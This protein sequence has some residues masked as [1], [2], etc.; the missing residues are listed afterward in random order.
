MSWLN[1]SDSHW[2]GNT[3]AA[4]IARRT[5]QRAAQ[6]GELTPTFPTMSSDGLHLPPATR[7]IAPQLYQQL[8]ALQDRP[9]VETG[10]LLAESPATGIPIIGRIWRTVRRSLHELVLFYV[11]RLVRDQTQR[12]TH[13]FNVVNELTRLTIQQ[14]QE[15]ARLRDELRGRD[16]A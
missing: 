7:Q 13:L 4:E 12:D 5:Q 6:Y 1:I 9:P 10:V 16:A 11:N 15:L 3:L 14:E 8:K 2:D